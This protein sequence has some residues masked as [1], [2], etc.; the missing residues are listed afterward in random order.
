MAA[1]ERI[2]RALRHAARRRPYHGREPPMLQTPLFLYG[3]GSLIC[4][5]CI[6]GHL[7]LGT[8]VGARVGAFVVGTN[9]KSVGTAV[10]F[11][12]PPQKQHIELAMKA[13]VSYWPH[14]LGE[15]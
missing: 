11:T 7:V 9:P 2:V 5:P 8:P 15:R 13:T 10:V 12:P 6:V 1:S 3:H 4:M 14:T